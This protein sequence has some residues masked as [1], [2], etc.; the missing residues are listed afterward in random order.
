MLGRELI[1]FG[2]YNIRNGRNGRLELS[3]QGM[4]QAN[5]DICIFQGTK[6]TGGVYTLGSDGYSSD[7]M[8][9]PRR[10]H[11]VLVVF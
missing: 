4:S 10:H 2:T 5:L 3:F 9:A 6:L 11:S 8:Y 7:A 1:Q